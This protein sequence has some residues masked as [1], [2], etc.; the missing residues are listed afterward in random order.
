[1]K[2]INSVTDALNTNKVLVDVGDGIV[3]PL[4]TDGVFGGAQGAPGVG[5]PEGGTSGQ[6]VQRTASGTIWA[7]PS[8]DLVGLTKV[9]NTADLE[10]P[11]SE[12]QALALTNKADLI[13][14]KV[15]A[16]QLPEI[17]PVTDS[18]IAPLIN[19][20]TTGAA[21]DARINTQVAPQVQK[22]T[23]EFI[24][25]DRAVVD[26]AAAAVNANPKI[27]EL[28]SNQFIKTTTSSWDFTKPGTYPN[29]TGA[30]SPTP[31]APQVWNVMVLAAPA[32]GSLIAV[33]FSH[34]NPSQLWAMRK[35]AGIWS[36][37]RRVGEDL[38]TKALSDAKTYADNL[39]ANIPSPAVSG[40]VGIHQH[41]IRLS[42]LRSRVGAPRMK[43][44][45]AITLIF[46]HG[47]NN[48]ASIVLPILRAAGLRCTLALNS[49]MYSPEYN[50]VAHENQTTWSQVRG[51]AVNDNIEIANHG[52]THRDTT[53]NA[54]IR[55]EIIGGREELEANLP[56]VNID[57][58]VTIGTT[59]D[60]N[61]W[62]G[63]NDGMA[64]SNY[65]ETYAGR[66]ILDGHA[67]ATGLAEHGGT[68]KR[69]YPLDG[70][71]KIGSS[72][73]W[74]DA[75]QAGIDQAKLKIDEAVALGGGVMIRMHPYLINW[76]NQISTAQLTD[77][78][79]YLKARQDAGEL[80]VLTYREWSLAVGW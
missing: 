61:K 49:Q 8:K 28:Q 57:T 25:G 46:D 6:V 56:G 67:L 43:G 22:I 63:F 3:V 34:S 20:A 52:R 36:P 5:V 7:T 16:S 66:C 74:L 48:F 27:A 73:Y 13:S 23:A 69:V 62:D 45:G 51:W 26:A 68:P 75:G 21:I 38:V 65:Y 32:A 71:P 12:P 42:H 64:L 59:G 50:H 79:N 37:W 76:T 18:T 4:P 54:A 55:A 33:A 77:F 17:T 35:S 44:K 31:D 9:D 72:G 47:T 30:G 80:E 1:M 15:P 53:G 70:H 14:G 58:F 40:D 24:A 39:V 10:K 78:I 2:R 19:G 29:W 11:L 60:G 41:E